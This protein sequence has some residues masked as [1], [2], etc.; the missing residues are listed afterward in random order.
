MILT[1]QPSGARKPLINGNFPNG[2]TTGLLEQPSQGAQ[3]STAPLL[4]SHQQ[5]V[6]T[7]LVGWAVEYTLLGFLAGR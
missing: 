2:S 1:F 7:G 4:K 6:F 3:A 5:G